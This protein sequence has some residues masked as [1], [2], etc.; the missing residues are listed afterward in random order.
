MPGD[1]KNWLPGRQLFD[2]GREF[3]ALHERELEVGYHQ[4]ELT[5][6]KQSE[7][8]STVV[9]LNNSM[10]VLG[11][12]LSDG[13]P[14]KSFIVNEQYALSKNLIL[15]HFSQAGKTSLSTR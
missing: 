1:R 2:F 5:S 12:Q 15:L 11:K 7:R 10:F 9:G 14:N 8:F 6:G 13:L 4:V 3:I